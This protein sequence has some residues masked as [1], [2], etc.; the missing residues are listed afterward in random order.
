RKET[1]APS[2][3]A[4][5]RLAVLIGALLGAVLSLGLGVKW[6]LYVNDP[7]T[8]SGMEIWR[9]MQDTQPDLKGKVTEAEQK[10]RGCYVLVSSAVLGL[11]GAALA[12]KG[13]AKPAGM[14]LVLGGVLPLPFAMSALLATAPLLLAGALSFVPQDG[15]A[16]PEPSLT[17]KRPVRPRP[18]G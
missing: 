18:R 2:R 12:Y 10:A 8:K 16:E 14:A 1:A 11:V 17:R 7:Q 9:K 13:Q 4:P 6:I 3:K 15:G 5:L